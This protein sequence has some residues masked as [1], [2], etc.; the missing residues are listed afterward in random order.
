MKA[1]DQVLNKLVDSM[2]EIRENVKETYEKELNNLL[3]V[4]KI[5]ENDLKLREF[6]NDWYVNLYDIREMDIYEKGS[7][8]KVLGR[9]W[10]VI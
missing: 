10:W 9:S 1:K 2:I 5:N 8:L 6:I 7:K 4:C 3:Q